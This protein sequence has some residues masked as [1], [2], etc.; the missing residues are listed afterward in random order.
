[1]RLFL[2]ALALPLLAGAAI[3]PDSIGT[4]QKTGTSSPKL[5]SQPVW[6][7]YGLKNAETVDYAGGG[8]TFAV[9]AY[10]LADSTAALGAFDWQRAAD[11]TASKAAPLAAETPKTLLVAQGNYLLLFDGYK[12]SADELEGVLGGLLNV[13]DTALPTLP[14]FM[15]SDGLVPNSERYIT[16]PAALQ[17][18]DPGIPPSVAAFH[19]SAEAQFGQFRS[20]KGAIGLAIFRYPTNQIAQQRMPDFEKL[21]GAVAKRS[22]PLVAV[23]LSPA[24]PD[25]AERL[26]S[27]VRYQADV[28]ASEYVPTRKDNIGDLVINAFIL[29]G[30]L[31]AGAI[32]AGF[33]MGGFRTFRRWGRKGEEPDP[34]ILL[35][36]DRL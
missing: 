2:A 11:A 13:D 28:T 17:A 33:C 16:G 6:D 4:Y 22:G 27:Q 1:M 18:F 8:T 30:M 19:L 14:G 32:F 35:H 20:P 31:A 26:L 25:A 9:T 5:S 36:L 21:P 34:M 23:I 29:I 24:D 3:L 15:P 10:Q 12:P 7:E